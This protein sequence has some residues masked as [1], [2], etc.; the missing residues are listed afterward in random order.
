MSI[1]SN[2]SKVLVSILTYSLTDVNKNSTL[3]IGLRNSL[4]S[5]SALFNI[6]FSII[7]VAILDALNTL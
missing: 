4:V 6:L 1:H 3:L 7:L 5:M 2:I